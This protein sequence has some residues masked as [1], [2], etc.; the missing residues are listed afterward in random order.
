MSTFHES[1]RSG[2]YKLSELKGSCQLI[3]M[4]MTFAAEGVLYLMFQEIAPK[5]ALKNTWLPP[6]GALLGFFVGV[7]GSV[8]VGQEGLIFTI[9]CQSSQS[10]GNRR[11]NQTANRVPRPT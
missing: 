1:G 9:N 8:L 3:S 7:L 5:V 6:M 10:I 11:I 4:I 2:W